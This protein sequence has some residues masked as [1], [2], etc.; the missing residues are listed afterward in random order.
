MIGQRDKNGVLHV[1]KTCA[2]NIPKDNEWHQVISEFKTS[3]NVSDINIY[4]KNSRGSVW[5]DEL[6]IQKMGN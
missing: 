6:N 3:E 2:G 5:I 4:N 1:I